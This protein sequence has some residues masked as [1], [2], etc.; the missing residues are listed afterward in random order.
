MMQKVNKMRPT[1]INISVKGN[2]IGILFILMTLICLGAC[3]PKHSSYSEFIEI[4]QNAWA[5]NTGYEF[6]PQYADSLIEYNVKVAFC[7]THEYPYRN[8]SAIV[9]FVKKDSVVVRKIVDFMLPQNQEFA[10]Y[11]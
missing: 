7:F 8:M 6:I 1:L 9:D 10:N 5:K 4:G 11:R 2:S 3:S